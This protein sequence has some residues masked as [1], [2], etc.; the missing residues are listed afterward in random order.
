VSRV[1]RPRSDGILSANALL[2][3]ITSVQSTPVSTNP[4]VLHFVLRRR[5]PGVVPVPMGLGD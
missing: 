3:L 2:K 5:A 1:R 4:T